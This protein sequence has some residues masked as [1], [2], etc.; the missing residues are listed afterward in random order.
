MKTIFRNDKVGKGSSNL[1]EVLEHNGRKFKIYVEISN[2]SCLG[3]NDKCCL[4]VMN[5]GGEFVDVV[6]NRQLGFYYKN[7]LYVTTFYDLIRREMAG[8][9]R[10]FYDFIEKVY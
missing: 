8:A 2:G 6:D 4:K 1:I 3:F 7:D 5:D 10:R 9:A